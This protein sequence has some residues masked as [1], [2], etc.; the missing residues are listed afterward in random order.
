MLAFTV[1]GKR[2]GKRKG[3]QVGERNK[4]FHVKFKMAVRHLN[5]DNLLVSMEHRETD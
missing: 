3:E 4:E 1:M 2:L 5:E